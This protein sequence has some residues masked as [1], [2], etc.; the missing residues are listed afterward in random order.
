MT[1]ELPTIRKIHH[2]KYWLLNLPWQKN[3]I[4]L[5]SAFHTKNKKKVYH[6]SFSYFLKIDKVKNFWG[7]LLQ[8]LGQMM[9]QEWVIMAVLPSS[10][11]QKKHSILL[12]IILFSKSEPSYGPS[13][14]I[15]ECNKILR[16]AKTRYFLD[17][18]MPFPPKV[19]WS[20]NSG[21][22]NKTRNTQNH[23]ISSITLFYSILIPP[24]HHPQRTQ[25]W[26]IILQEIFIQRIRHN[27]SP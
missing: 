4:I 19:K 17:P 27:K 20:N 13:V 23:S 9:E 8:N 25:N 5:C 12:K 11:P 2:K 16:A 26:C 6:Q 1:T 7:S 24:L 22:S 15:S 18:P 3:V 21:H 14:P 10:H